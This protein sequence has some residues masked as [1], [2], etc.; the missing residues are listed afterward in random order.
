VALAK[1]QGAVRIEN[2]LM[3]DERLRQMYT[4]MVQVRMLEEWI[5]GKARGGKG[6]RAVEREFVT[7][8]GK[9][10]ARAST[11]LSLEAGDLLSDC[12]EAPGM[13]LL[14]G[15]SLA[16]VRRRVRSK[17]AEKEEAREGASHVLR[18]PVSP[19][20]EE[21][22]ELALGAAA[23]LRVQGGGR[24][25][26]V[27]AG[28]GE[29]GAKRWKRAL[30]RAGERELPVIFVLLP[31]D[32]DEDVAE[33]AGEVARRSR[34]W[35]VPGFPV[36]GAD[37]IGLYRVMQESLLRARTGGGPALMECIRFEVHGAKRVKPE[38]PIER[39]E[40]LMVAKGA[41]SAEWMRRTRSA[42]A[43]RLGGGR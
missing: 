23:A 3:P 36:D 18:L 16:A 4:A 17:G 12:A 38:D 1:V 10:A 5:E 28:A 35:G 32:A 22:L 31:P 14:L 39:L 19:D 42:F 24:V 21:R 34:G 29:I 9:E 11:A 30:Q 25:L 43:R 6:K 20:G 33:E 7:L 41:G 26:L 37:A 27:Y 15:A 13:D 40:E 8:R 2:P